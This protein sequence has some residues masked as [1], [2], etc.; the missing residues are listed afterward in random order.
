M[1]YLAMDSKILAC[2]QD[3]VDFQ[4]LRDVPVRFEI[5]L[6]YVSFNYSDNYA[7]TITKSDFLEML[8]ELVDCGMINV[9]EDLY[10]T[11]E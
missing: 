1:K 8:W 9:E 6:E 10:G 5:D 3:R 11:M 7:V 4:L 2:I